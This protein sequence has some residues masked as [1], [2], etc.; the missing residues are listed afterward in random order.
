MK[1]AAIVNVES[2]C[3]T[4]GSTRV[5]SFPEGMSLRK[6]TFVRVAFGEKEEYVGKLLTDTM[7]LDESAYTSL[8][9]HIN[10]LGSKIDIRAAAE[11]QMTDKPFEVV[12]TNL[13][14][15]FLEGPFENHYGNVGEPA[16]FKDKLGV[17]LFV[18]D[19]VHLFD[20]DGEYIGKRFVVKD[21]DGEAFVM[22]IKSACIR[23]GGKTGMG[24]D[25]HLYKRHERVPGGE[26]YG[27]VRMVR[28]EWAG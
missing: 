17:D 10:P 15:R 16:G 19:V 24:F 28:K 12:E 7:T 6:G 9:E 21:E 13:P 20:A 14:E 5:V 27:G 1:N 23:P 4:R 25:V 3:S 2:K 18:G 26:E 22:G 11:I 8:C